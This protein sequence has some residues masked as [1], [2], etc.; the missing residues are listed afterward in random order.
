MDLVTYGRHYDIR[1]LKSDAIRINNERKS[2]SKQ[3][4]GGYGGGTGAKVK[5]QK[6]HKSFACPI[7]R[8][9]KPNEKN[10]SNVKKIVD[11]SASL[12]IS[13]SINFPDCALKV[14]DVYIDTGADMTLVSEGLASRLITHEKKI[15]LLFVEEDRWFERVLVLLIQGKGKVFTVSAGVVSTAIMISTNYA[16]IL[17]GLDSIKYSEKF[18]IDYDML[19]VDIFD[20]KVSAQIACQERAPSITIRRQAKISVLESHVKI[21]DKEVSLLAKDY[22]DLI[23]DKKEKLEILPY[24][25]EPLKFTTEEMPKIVKR[26]NTCVKKIATY[27]PTLNVIISEFCG[28]NFF[29]QVNLEAGYHYVQLDVSIQDYFAVF[30]PMGLFRICRLP[31]GFTNAGVAVASLMWYGYLVCSSRSG[32]SKYNGSTGSFFKEGME[33]KFNQTCGESFNLINEILS[34]QPRLMIADGKKEFFL[35]VNSS[36][37][38][39]GAVL[40]QKDD[41]SKLVLLAYY[42]KLFQ[43]LKKPTS[44]TML[45]LKEIIATIRH[46][47]ELNKT[48]LIKSE[49]FLILKPLLGKLCHRKAEELFQYLSVVEEAGCRIK[50]QQGL[51]MYASDVLSRIYIRRHLA[52]EGGKN[53]T[54]KDDIKE[55]MDDETLLRN[56]HERWCHLDYR[57]MSNLLKRYEV[58]R[59]NLQKMCEK[60]CL[61]C[62]SCQK[63]QHSSEEKV[64]KEY[65]CSVVL[66]GRPKILKADNAQTFALTYF[67]EKVIEAEKLKLGIPHHS[68]SQSLIERLFGTVYRILKKVYLD[69][70]RRGEEMDYQT[71]CYGISKIF[72]ET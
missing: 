13:I 5:H 7:K 51:K 2:Q 32:S 25:V 24:V 52:V 12:I 56:L 62:E 67:R 43:L 57:K 35:E 46:F 14:L 68:I 30:T 41:S 42:S 27:L 16:H 44:V 53:T 21:F 29:L 50:Y 48:L 19:E 55:N 71:L 37:D 59:P 45:K 4:T 26:L 17:L 65:L 69:Q 31:F 28:A 66:Y 61:T 23:T 22:P 33:Y 39:C 64:G 6:N 1:T 3:R 72:N 40:L 18:S 20:R 36:L 11:R 34:K 47:K 54:H 49:I 9:T 70:Q 38:S 60:A 63:D 8:F 15:K 10:V 58:N